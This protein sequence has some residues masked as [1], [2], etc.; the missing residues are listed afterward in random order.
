MLLEVSSTQDGDALRDGL[1]AVLAAGLEDGLVEDA[2]LA[3]TE[4]QRSQIW[5]MREAVPLSQKAEGGSIK[6]DVSVPVSRVAEFIEVASAA[7]IAAMPGVRPIAFGH[8]GDG[9]MHFNLTEPEGMDTDAFMAERQAM[10]RVV[11]D[12]VAGMGGS[13]S[14]EHGIGQLKRGELVRYRSETELGLM[15]AIKATLDPQGI[16][17]PGKVL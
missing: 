6:H 3:G 16:M 15:R 10:N 5:H 9:N 11:Y 8:V 13:I 2:V 12:V 1:E 17:N 7:C 14:A 4:A